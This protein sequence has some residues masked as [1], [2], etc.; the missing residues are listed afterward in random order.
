MQTC[1]QRWALDWTWIGLDPDYIKFCNFVTVNLFKIQ[2][3]DRISTE[4][5][6]KEMRHYCC[7]KATFFIFLDLVETIF[8]LWLDLDWVLKNLDWI[9]IAKCDSPFISACG[10]T[11]LSLRF[12]SDFL[13]STKCKIIFAAASFRNSAAQ[14]F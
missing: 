5:N 7:E 13:V 3:L 11:S 12:I 4:F 14:F 10:N 2:D 1:G 6:E 9:W 8:G